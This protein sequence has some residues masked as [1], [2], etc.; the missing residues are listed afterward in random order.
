MPKEDFVKEYMDVREATFRS[1]TI[2]SAFKKSGIWPVDWSVFTDDDFAPSIPYSTEAQD[3]PS[4][5]EL[6]EVDELSDSGSDFDSYDSDVDTDSN[7][8]CRNHFRQ[9]TTP[10]SASST[11]KQVQLSSQHSMSPTHEQA[12]SSI[13]QALSFTDSTPFSVGPIPPERFYHNPAVFDRI[14]ASA[15]TLGAH[16]NG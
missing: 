14:Q 6:P 15:A 10:Q 13:P 11:A 12:Q 3:L 7:S 2:V 1:S 16:Q 8:H 9:S 5:L 4:L